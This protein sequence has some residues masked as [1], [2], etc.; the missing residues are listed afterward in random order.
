MEL[1]NSVIHTSLYVV[2]EIRAL[3]AICNIHA[4]LYEICEIR[5][6]YA[7]CNI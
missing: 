5:A 1:A 7:V 3:H 6:L 4:S 2:Y